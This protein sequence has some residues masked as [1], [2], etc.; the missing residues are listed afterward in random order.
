MQSIFPC[1]INLSELPS[2]PFLN[3]ELFPDIPCVYFVLNSQDKLLYIGQSTCAFRFLA[4]IVS[5]A[6]TRRALIRQTPYLTSLL[7]GI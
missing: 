1:F 4:D 3:R 2:A 7:A 6:P 5:S